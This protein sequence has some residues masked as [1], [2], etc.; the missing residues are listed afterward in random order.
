LVEKGTIELD[1][2]NNKIAKADLSPLK[3][4]STRNIFPEDAYKADGSETVFVDGIYMSDKTGDVKHVSVGR[5][6][7]L[8]L[9][10]TKNIDPLET[11]SN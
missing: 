6:K 2:R 1:L 11:L 9:V 5:N 4:V 7:K 8:L 3:M 10:S